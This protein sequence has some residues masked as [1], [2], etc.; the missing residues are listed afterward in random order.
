MYQKIILILFFS[1]SLL[2][3]DYVLKVDK[4]E[5][6]KIDRM[7]KNSVADMKHI[8]QNPTFYADQIKPFSTKE[9]RALDEKFNEKYFKPWDL[10]KLDIPD[11]FAFIIRAGG[12]NLRYSEF[13]ISFAISSIVC[14]GSPIIFPE[15]FRYPNSLSHLEHLTL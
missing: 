9:Q 14:P 3:A 6:S 1:I 13:K 7:P 10:K 2:H 15:P 11:N 4:R 8:P 5:K 12:A